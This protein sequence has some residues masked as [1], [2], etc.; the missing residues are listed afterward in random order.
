MSKINGALNGIYQ[1]FDPQI[2]QQVGLGTMDRSVT[3]PFVRSLTCYHK[4]VRNFDNFFQ[5][6][7]LFLC[8]HATSSI[9]KFMQI[10]FFGNKTAFLLQVKIII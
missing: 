6:K 10:D 7:N 2:S 4:F 9:H 3:T 1:M 5:I 8:N